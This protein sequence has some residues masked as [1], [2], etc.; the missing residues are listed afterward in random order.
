LKH[1]LRLVEDSTEEMLTYYRLLLA[2]HNHMNGLNMIERLKRRTP[3]Q[4]VGASPCGSGASFRQ[5]S[6][7]VCVAREAATRER[8]TFGDRV[9]TVLAMLIYIA[10]V[11]AFPALVIKITRKCRRTSAPS[12]VARFYDCRAT[13]RNAEN[14]Q[15]NL[16]IDAQ[17]GSSSPAISSHPCRGLR[18]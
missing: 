2:H 10:I 18:H 7:V 9:I 5:P 12:V 11:V 1:R 8:T 14:A 4:C 16:K 17:T 15:Q 3:T 6:C 13:D